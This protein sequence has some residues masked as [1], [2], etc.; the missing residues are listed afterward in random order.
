MGRLDNQQENPVGR[1]P[2]EVVTA[3]R[4]V[5][6]VQSPPSR[7]NFITNAP[8]NIGAL[9]RGEISV[10]D[11]AR[12]VPGVVKRG[13]IKTA[14]T[15]TPALTNFVKTTGGIIGE[16]AA[17][18]IDPNVRKQYKAG[19][20][21][22]LPTVTKTTQKGL[23]KDTVA[24]G[25]EAT[26]I[27][28]LPASLKGKIA[29]RAGI[30]GLEGIGFAISEG[31]AKDQ[32]AEEIL[33]NAKLY[34]VS[35]SALNVVLPWLG[36]LLRKELS[37]APQGLRNAL[38]KEVEDEAPSV[39]SYI[40]KNDEKVYTTISKEEL[41]RLKNE[42]AN[43]PEAAKGESQIH[44]DAK[45]KT[46]ESQGKLVSR[47]EFIA[48]HSQAGDLLGAPK[49]APKTPTGVLEVQG[50][51][52]PIG[53]PTKGASRLEARLVEQVEDPT[54][55]AGVS[56]YAR[57][58]Q[59]AD[60]P[61]ITGSSNA[62]QI[63]RAAQAVNN[64]TPSQINDIVTGTAELPQGVLRTAFI[65]AATEKALEAGDTALVNRLARAVGQAARRFGQEIQFTKNFDPLDPTY[66]I[67]DILA[68]RV[69]AAERRLGGGETVASYTRKNVEKAKKETVKSQVKIAQAQDLIDSILC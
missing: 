66:N 10:G 37:K 51:Q 22:V 50:E 27:R 29:T 23:L 30:G 54:Y 59:A 1:L 33:D 16:G 24:A 40:N 6:T 31:M 41:G 58:S 62:E 9:F 2:R 4:E 20:L 15:V 14:E 53:G 47:D 18:A 56:N 46:L 42:V 12:E 34:G 61:E 8:S 25:L 48:G 68:V 63:K 65:K 69:K 45:T 38:K 60:A 64:L 36:P 21:D 17:Y 55:Q 35:G 26:I 13:S 57:Y 67:A 11:V 7:G 39:I 52:I 49:V 5:D 3:Q 32:T 44:L 19:N 28:S 43:I